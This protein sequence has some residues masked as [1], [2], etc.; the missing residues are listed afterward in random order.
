M[1]KLTAVGKTKIISILCQSIQRLN[2][3]PDSETI[4]VSGFSCRKITITVAEIQ[5]K[6]SYND[7]LSG[8]EIDYLAKLLWKELIFQ[9]ITK[10]RK[11]NSLKQLQLQ[12]ARDTN[13]EERNRI[14][15]SLD[16][17]IKTNNKSNNHQQNDSDLI[18]FLNDEACYEAYKTFYITNGSFRTCQRFLQASAKESQSST[19]VK[20]LVNTVNNLAQSLKIDIFD[21]N[22]L[23]LFEYQQK[24]LKPEV[25]LSI[26]KESLQ[27]L[28]NILQNLRKIF[29]NDNN[30]PDI[31]KIQQYYLEKSGWNTLKRGKKPDLLTYLSERKENTLLRF[32]AHLIKSTNNDL[33]EELTNWLTVK[34]CFFA[35]TPQE[36]DADQFLRQF[37]ILLDMNDNLPHSQSS[38]QSFLMIS[39]KKSN[40]NYKISCWF[41]SENQSTPRNIHQSTLTN[42]REINQELDNTVQNCMNQ[43][44]EK[45]WLGFHEAISSMRIELFVDYNLI[46]LDYYAW[47]F[48]IGRK[49]RRLPNIILR[50]QERQELVQMLNDKKSLSSSTRQELTE[51][52]EQ[53]NQKW[54]QLNNNQGNFGLKSQ[55]PSPYIG[56]KSWNSLTHY[57]LE[58]L[59]DDSLPAAIWYR[60]KNDQFRQEMI[61]TTINNLLKNNINQLPDK[62][63]KIRKQANGNPTEVASHLSLLWDPPNRPLPPEPDSENYPLGLF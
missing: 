4:L 24:D 45:E 33:A 46:N 14:N 19:T 23:F 48:K 15:Y 1:P 17:I 30:L 54:N 22:D 51:Q 2:R 20:Y 11:I 56:L 42:L 60:N 62:L 34:G 29:S 57:C 28:R 59:I 49:K 12:F 13:E 39:F 40:N 36:F 58:Y 26:K 31:S 3:W 8:Y 52:N 35:Q 55:M 16:T 9:K 38:P 50:L 7:N 18:N 27:N 32:I 47:E 53:W 21:I 43:I 25:I 6:L 44:I 10:N 5:K 37:T 61:E 41:A 63:S